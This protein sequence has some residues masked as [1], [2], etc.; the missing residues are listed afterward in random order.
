MRLIQASGLCRFALAEGGAITNDCLGTEDSSSEPD[1]ESA[2][3]RAEMALTSWLP[4]NLQDIPRSFPAWRCAGFNGRW[5]VSGA[6]LGRH[7]EGHLLLLVFGQGSLHRLCMDVCKDK[8]KEFNM[9]NRVGY[10]NCKL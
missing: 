8:Q 5:H 1:D 10:F 3:E 9:Y 4:S 7:G 6:P 2:R